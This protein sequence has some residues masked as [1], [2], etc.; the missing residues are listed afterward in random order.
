GGVMNGVDVAV[1][2]GATV[3]KAGKT[4]SDGL[5]SFNLSV[6]QYQ[7][8][9]TTPDFKTHAQ[10]IRVVP[11]MPAIAITLSLEGITSVVEVTADS[12][13]QIIIDASQSLDA[14]VLTQEQI[15]D[16]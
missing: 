11:N 15:N 9:V 3:V 14:T 1:L 12:R 6:G 16:L 2:Q 5:F 10:A 8:V 13:N 7:L 4:D